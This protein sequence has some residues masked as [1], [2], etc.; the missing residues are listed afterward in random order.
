MRE[1]KDTPSRAQPLHGTQYHV[2]KRNDAVLSTVKKTASGRWE[3]MTKN[4]VASRPHRQKRQ[5]DNNY[6]L[7]CTF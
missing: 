2:Q 6:C 3:V 4:K 7:N 1:T 5:I